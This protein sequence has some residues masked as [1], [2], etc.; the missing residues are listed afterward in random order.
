LVSPS[1]RS[2]TAQLQLSQFVSAAA[3]VRRPQPSKKYTCRETIHIACGE[4]RVIG[5]DGLYTGLPLDQIASF[6]H[7]AWKNPPLVAPVSLHRGLSPFV[8]WTETSGKIERT[9]RD[10]ILVA[11]IL[12]SVPICFFKPY[13][14]ILLWVWV[15]YF[16]PHRFTWGFAYSFPLATVIAIPTLLGIVFTRKVNRHPWVLQTVLLLAFWAWICFT[17]VVATHVP[18]F[19][20]HIEEGKLQLIE[21]SKVLLMTFVVIFLVDSRK[22]LE[23]LFLVTALSFGILALKGAL[24]GIRTSG[25]FRVWGPPGSFIA[26]NND[27]GLALNMTLP[28]MFFLARE[29]T[30]RWLRLLLWASFFAS[31]LAVI[32]TYSRGALLGL[33]VVLGALL[34]KARRKV[35]G[36]VLLIAA[37]FFVIAFAPSAWM[38]RMG[39]FAHGQVDN[40]AQGRLDAWHFAWALAS[41]YPIT[42]GGFET[43]TPGLY[44]RFTPELSFA[45]PHSIYF[46]T[47]GDQGFVGL[48]IFLL[49]LGSCFYSLRRIRRQVRGQPSLAWIKNYSSMLEACL[50]GYIVSGAF[51]PRAYFDLWFQLAAA[52]ALLKIL[53]RQEREFPAMEAVV[54]QALVGQEVVS[55]A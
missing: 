2:S 41:H 26:D 32:L 13:F 6:F 8:A 27:F 10:I 12:G 30:N 38:D 31:V 18:I 29:T 1:G 16:N 39:N 20:D 36:G 54:S 53:Y 48:G 33:V 44:Q 21:V 7:A 45:G 43:F 25:E 35:L 37:A 3:V 42:G 28:M 40:S 51:L 14:G 22:K 50:L 46:Q 15:A 34:L 9:M 19:A 11:I 52:T 23:G 49:T 47:L 5:S 24:F 55:I 17:W 4:C